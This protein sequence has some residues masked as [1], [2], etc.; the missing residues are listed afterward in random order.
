MRGDR[1]AAQ[2]P[3]CWRILATPHARGSTHAHAPFGQSRPGYPACAGIDPCCFRASRPPRRLPR[4]RGDRPTPHFQHTIVPVATPHAR[5]STWDICSMPSPW[6]GYPACAGIDRSRIRDSISAPR[7]PRMRG[8]RPRLA[9]EAEVAQRATPHARGSTWQNSCAIENRLGYPA[10]A[11]ID[12]DSAVR[13]SRRH[14]LPRMRGD[15]PETGEHGERHGPA[16]PHAR[17]STRSASQTT[18]Q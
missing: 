1:P 4:M 14:R 3:A 7:L 2:I 16:T 17:G 5:G 15:R 11:G 6:R 8:D 9:K 10:C 12:L 13:M 18:S